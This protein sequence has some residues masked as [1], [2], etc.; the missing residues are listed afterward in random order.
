[1]K[2]ERRCSTKILKKVYFS[3]AAFFMKRIYH[4]FIEFSKKNLQT[5]F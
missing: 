2:Y 3:D 5:Y 1:M 4:S